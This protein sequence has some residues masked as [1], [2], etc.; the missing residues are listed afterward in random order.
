MSDQCRHCTL[1]G[2]LPACKAVECFQHE[3]W[4]SLVQQKLIEAYQNELIELKS[5][6]QSHERANLILSQKGR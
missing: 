6:L 1:R 2:D 5:K 3:S 4:Y